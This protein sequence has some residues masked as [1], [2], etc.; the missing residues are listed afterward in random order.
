MSDHTLP[1]WRP[2]PDT[3]E[4]LLGFWFFGPTILAAIACGF[5]IEGSDEFLFTFAIVAGAGAIYSVCYL[6]YKWINGPSGKMKLGPWLVMWIG[7]STI[8]LAL[9]LASIRKPEAPALA[10][11]IIL[12]SFLI[13]SLLHAIT[14]WITQTNP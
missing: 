12:G 2:T 4:T 3:R 11:S 9:Y 1:W 5:I 6:V 14:G 8:A 10:A 7:A 13:E